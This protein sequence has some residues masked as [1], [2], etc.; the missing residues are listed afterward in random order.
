MMNKPLTAILPEEY[1]QSNLLNHIPTHNKD[2]E[3]YQYLIAGLCCPVVSKL[4][5]LHFCTKR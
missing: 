2:A 1:I 4:C 5:P 3:V